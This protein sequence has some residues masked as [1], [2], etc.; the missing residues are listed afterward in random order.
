MFFPIDRT[1]AWWP[2]QLDWMQSLPLHQHHAHS[3][4]MP[5]PRCDWSVWE[6]KQTSPDVFGETFRLL[7]LSK[8]NKNKKDVFP[9]ATVAHFLYRHNTHGARWRNRQHAVPALR[10]SNGESIPPLHPIQLVILFLLFTKHPS[11]ERKGK[12]CDEKISQ[13]ALQQQFRVTCLF[14]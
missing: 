14:G 12:W 11:P 8:N 3:Q 9:F 5:T 10:C 6:C 2:W 1:I 7:C 4:K 13:E